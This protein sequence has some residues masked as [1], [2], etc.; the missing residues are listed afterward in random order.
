MKKIVLIVLSTL[1][2]LSFAGCNALPKLSAIV[3]TNAP[4]A[5]E[6]PNATVDPNATQDPGTTDGRQ[7]V[8]LVAYT[9]GK[10]ASF[11]T[12]NSVPEPPFL[13][14]NVTAFVSAANS[15]WVTVKD[16]TEAQVETYAATLEAAGYAKSVI[17]SAD[18]KMY[19]FSNE[20]N[21]VSAIISYTPKEDTQC[22]VTFSLVS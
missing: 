16:A 18:G 2:M 22:T 17:S 1:L 6:D 11:I 10:D 3:P 13:A 19:T 9:W 4:V 7:D 12:D 14:N 8:P 20:T 15:H 5:T 21:K